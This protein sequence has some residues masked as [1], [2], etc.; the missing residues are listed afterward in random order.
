MNFFHLFFV[1][2]TSNALPWLPD[3]THSF[4][5]CQG[6]SATQSGWAQHPV[7][8]RT[9]RAIEVESVYQRS[10]WAEVEFAN[11]S[12]PPFWINTHDPIA[13]D[14]FISAAAHFSAKP[15][16]SYIWDVMVHI[17]TQMHTPRDGVVV[18]CGANI[19]YFTLAAASLGYNVVAFEPLSRN[20]KKLFLSVMMNEQVD[21]VDL[22]MNAV[23][24]ANGE[25]F[26]IKETDETN[27]GNGHIWDIPAHDAVRGS[28]K[29]GID[30]TETVTLSDTVRSHVVFMKI[31]VEGY[32][33]L[34]LD[35]AR[36]LLD[37]FIVHN[38]V[39][40]LSDLTKR[41][42][43]CNVVEMLKT[44]QK[45]YGYKITDVVVEGSE[46]DAEHIESMP[47]NIWLSLKN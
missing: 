2:T 20:A 39:L 17:L 42:A 22:Y 36:G 14:R 41:S 38:I 1:L 13:Q 28:H 46:L 19:G 26:Y 29:L 5:W 11:S 12:V 25:R 8:S 43:R 21:L 18:D 31:D 9:Y 7:N 10:F 44:L 4:G 30:Y 16:D 24:A 27:Q 6:P 47:P 34:V 40:E 23:G 45:K 35:G 37:R 32:E 15:W 33:A 3:Q